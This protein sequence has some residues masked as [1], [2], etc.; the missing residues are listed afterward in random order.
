ME[1]GRP[2]SRLATPRLP[3]PDPSGFVERPL[4]PIIIRTGETESEHTSC[5]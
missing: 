2:Q 1:E 4:N 3:L 5:A